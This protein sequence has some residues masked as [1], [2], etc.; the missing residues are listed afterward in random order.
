MTV[1]FIEFMSRDGLGLEFYL[2]VFDVKVTESN[3]EPVTNYVNVDTKLALTEFIGEKTFVEFSRFEIFTDDYYPWSSVTKINGSYVSN[4]RWSPLVVN[5]TK[6]PLLSSVIFTTNEKLIVY[7]RRVAKL[8]DAFSIT[9]GFFS[10]LIT[11]CGILLFSYNSYVYNLEVARHTF[12]EDDGSMRNSKF[13]NI[14][15]FFKYSV[16]S[17]V[18]LFG[19]KLNW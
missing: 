3:F 7:D 8:T 9:G 6:R 10:F 16:Y 11:V 2:Y 19:K 17:F 13:T 18:R 15:Y 1:S 14:L 4:V 12:K 5:I